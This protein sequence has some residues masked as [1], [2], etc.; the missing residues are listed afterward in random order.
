MTA[1]DT[2]TPLANDAR[3]AVANEGWVVAAMVERGHQKAAI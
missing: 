3:I 2:E 1:K